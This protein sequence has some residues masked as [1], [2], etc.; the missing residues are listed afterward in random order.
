[1]NKL[2]KYIILI[3]IGIILYL[4]FNLKEKFNIG[5]PWRFYK[6]NGEYRVDSDNIL[7]TRNV[8]SSNFN[9]G[10][11]HANYTQKSFDRDTMIYDGGIP[12]PE[13][14]G[15]L[16]DTN[17]PLIFDSETLKPTEKYRYID[18]PDYIS[19]YNPNLNSGYNAEF[20]INI[21]TNNTLNA[22]KILMKDVHISH[23]LE[24]YNNF[25]QYTNIENRIDMY[26]LLMIDNESLLKIYSM[27]NKYYMKHKNV[28]DKSIP[29][30]ILYFTCHA[31]WLSNEFNEELNIETPSSFTKVHK[32]YTENPPGKTSGKGCTYV[33]Y[34]KN[35]NMGY[36]KDPTKVF[37]DYPGTPIEKS[38]YKY[39]LYYRSDEFTRISNESLL[40]TTSCSMNIVYQS[41]NGDYYQY[42]SSKIKKDNGDIDYQLWRKNIRMLRLFGLTAYDKRCNASG[43]IIEDSEVPI[44]LTSYNLKQSIDT[45]VTTS[46]TPTVRERLNKMRSSI[47]SRNKF[48]P[49]SIYTIQGL[50]TAIINKLK[51]FDTPIAVKRNGGNYTNLEYPLKLLVSGCIKSKEKN[52]SYTFNEITQLI[53]YQ[54]A[55]KYD[56]RDY[57]LPNYLINEIFVNTYAQETDAIDQYLEMTHPLEYDLDQIQQ[58]IDDI[59]TNTNLVD[60]I[61][62]VDL[63]DDPDEQ[64]G[65]ELM[66]QRTGIAQRCDPTEHLHDEP[67]EEEQPPRTRRRINPDSCASRRT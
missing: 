31:Q 5:I 25:K 29:Q 64:D 21:H 34:K 1:M 56:I 52:R 28:P 55:Y 66:R 23:F 26:K 59:L 67:E 45:T 50:R 7:I 24:V 58:D 10:I 14:I 16:V 6:T 47:S 54:T 62:D 15:Y 4:L 42:G 37:N 3:F 22:D 2:F 32:V 65:T 11:D 40:N 30:P 57:R 20:N 46:T 43:I 36:Q 38:I 35:F 18:D 9:N 48:P 33:S 8:D 39:P 60:E 41:V 63:P 49:Y 44:L 61:D 51:S 19:L 17:D 12:K 53:A 13:Q 27:I